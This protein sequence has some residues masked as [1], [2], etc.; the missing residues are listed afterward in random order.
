MGLASDFMAAQPNRSKLVGCRQH[1]NGAVSAEACAGD[2]ERTADAIALDDRYTDVASRS[3]YVVERERDDRFGI[4]H[5][6]FL[7]RDV[8]GKISR[9]LAA[10][11]SIGRF[12][13]SGARLFERDTEAVRL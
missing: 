10:D 4:S 13:L 11:F 2:V 5:R 8:A 6:E 12:R 3:R 1:A 9:Y 7:G